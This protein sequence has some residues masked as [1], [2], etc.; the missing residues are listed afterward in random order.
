MEI[1]CKNCAVELQPHYDFCPKC[2]QKAKLHR[3]SLHEVAHEGIHYFTHADK[4]VFQLIRDLAKKGGVVAREYVEG[5]RK[6]YFPPLNFF[7]LVTAVYVF[8]MSFSDHST[9]KVDMLKK[10]PELAAIQD[11]QQQEKIV[12][13]YQKRDEGIALINKHSN[14]LSMISLPITAFIFWLLY[15]KGRYNY[16]EHLVACMYM[17]GF[18]TLGF[19]VLITLLNFLFKININYIFVG[20]FVLQLVY[21]SMFYYSFLGEYTRRKA[22]KA[23]GA[24]LISLVSLF[25][26]SGVV[27]WLF[28]TNVIG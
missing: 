24:T 25:V 28:M 10:Y 4:G 8:V 5:K 7:L 16:T 3:L 2:S 9:G 22:L 17:Y 26:V 21:F 15:R 14:L 18:S 20:Y 19:V 6:K 12:A 11:K 13:L 23:F 27:M 1:T